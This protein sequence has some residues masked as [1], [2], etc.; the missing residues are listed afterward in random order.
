[1]S[2]RF[3]DTEKWKDPWFSELPMNYKL[4]WMY[5]LD[6]CDNSGIYQI[7]LKLANFQLGF[8]VDLKKLVSLFGA[9]IQLINSEKLLIKKFAEFQYGSF[10][11]SKNPFHKKLVDQINSFSTPCLHP[12]DTVS[13][14]V[15]D[16]VSYTLQEQVQVQDKDKEQDNGKKNKFIPPVLEEVKTYFKENGYSEESASKFFQYYESASWVDAQGSHVKSWKQK[17]I[18]VWF[19]PENKLQPVKLKPHDIVRN[20]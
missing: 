14:T 18:A 16:R 20:W 17:A 12:I 19:K 6:V 1:M 4:F 2:K 3:T 10:R 5:I 8:K 13:D 11:N 7:N 15:S 9:R